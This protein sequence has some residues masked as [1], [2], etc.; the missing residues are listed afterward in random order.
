MYG[1]LFLLG[2][3]LAMDRLPGRALSFAA[4]A[5]LLG[6]VL[7]G[8]SLYAVALVPDTLRGT[9]G[10]IAPL[11]GSL[12]IAAWIA[13]KIAPTKFGRGYAEVDPKSWT[14]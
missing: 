4:W 2:I 3:G 11:G 1:A 7:F 12:M 14:T 9:F 13:K 8:V 10:R 5:M 6:V